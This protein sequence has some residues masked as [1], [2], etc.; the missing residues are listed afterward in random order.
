[1]PSPLIIDGATGTELERRGVN[2]GLPLWSARA[3]LDAP[4]V[5][6]QVHADYLEAGAGAIVTNTFRTHRRSL[7]KEGLG[8]RAGELTRRAVEIACSAR[9]RVRGDA[10][11]LGSVAPLEDCYHP[12]LMP[13]ES[14]CAAEHGEMITTLCDAG[15]DYVLLETMNAQVEALAAA[16]VARETVPGKWMISFCLKDTGPPGQTLLGRD[17]PDILPPLHDA[18][19]VGVNCMPAPT[20]GPQVKLLRA[21]LPSHVRVMAYGNVG[22]QLDDGRWVETDAVDPETYAGYAAEWVEAGAQIVGGCCGTTPE[23][24]RAMARRVW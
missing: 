9:D 19:A 22:R 12:E 1:M 15:V 21:L 16:R 13:A 17:L 11:V 24:I 5:L 2:I 8:D 23:T 10:L 14:V 3:L 6:E 4:E 18:Y 20:I 7:E